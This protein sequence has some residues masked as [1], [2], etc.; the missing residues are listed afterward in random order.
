MD[1]YRGLIRYADRASNIADQLDTPTLL[2]YGG[3]DKSVPAVS[4][5]RLRTHLGARAEYQFYD[6]GP[7]LLLQGRD[8]QTVAEHTL[9]WLEHSHVSEP[10]MA[11]LI[12]SDAN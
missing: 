12:Y 6:S 9:N 1:A 7:H 4:I 3:K 2:M 11:E 5:E 10:A 8:W